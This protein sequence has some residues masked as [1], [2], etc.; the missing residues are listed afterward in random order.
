MCLWMFLLWPVL[1]MLSPKHSSFLCRLNGYR[2]QH[3]HNFRRLR[4]LGACAVLRRKPQRP[5]GRGKAPEVTRRCTTRRS[6]ASSRL[7][8]FCSRKAPRW[9]PRTKMARGLKG[10]A[11]K[12]CLRLG[13]LQNTFWVWNSEKNA[14]MF[15]KCLAKFWL[16]TPK[17]A[18]NAGINDHV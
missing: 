12:S 15:S 3:A 13:A 7:R 16:S 9:T 17:H 10:R 1:K 5:T 14:C 11:M 8:I 6:T 2:A 4:C 18:T